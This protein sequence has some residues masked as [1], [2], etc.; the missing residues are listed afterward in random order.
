[1]SS[2]LERC[3]RAIFEATAAKWSGEHWDEVDHNQY[4]KEA[5]AVLSELMEPDE[6]MLAACE[7]Q[8]TPLGAGRFMC[9]ADTQ[10]WQLMLT[11]ALTEKPE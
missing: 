7:V 8:A 1:M 4:L 10:V 9:R 6:A 3:A 2:M 5:R 11:T